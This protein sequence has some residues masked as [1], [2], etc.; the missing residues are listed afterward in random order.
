MTAVVLALPVVILPLITWLL[1]DIGRQQTRRE[2]ARLAANEINR[3]A[4]RR[5]EEAA[6]KAEAKR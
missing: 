5:L 6:H 2:A 1:W 4:A 3:D